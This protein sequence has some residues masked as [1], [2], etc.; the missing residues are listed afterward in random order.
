MNTLEPIHWQGFRP[1]D[2]LILLAL[3]LLGLATLAFNFI[4]QAFLRRLARLPGGQP[5]VVWLVRGNNLWLVAAGFVLLAVTYLMWLRHRMMNDRR[6]WF[7]TGCPTCKELELVRVSREKSD[8]Y[9]EVIRIRAYRYACRNCSWRGL[10]IARREHAQERD[11]EM[12]MALRQVQ[13]DELVPA[14]LQGWPAAQPAEGLG[15]EPN[16]GLAS[17]SDGLEGAAWQEPHGDKQKDDDPLEGDDTT[18]PGEQ[19]N[20]H[21]EEAVDELEWL[22]RR[23]SD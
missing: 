17:P 21:D 23:S 19:N 5:L 10:R 13:S 4:D 6:L 11:L 1:L 16:P 18:D 15:L 12:E 3:P 20:H 9:Y 7:G 2:K 14:N 8:R 22:W